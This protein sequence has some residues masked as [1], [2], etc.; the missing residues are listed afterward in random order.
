VLPEALEK[1]PVDLLGNLLPRHLEIIYLINHYF[2]QEVGAKFAADDQ[3]RHENM[4]AMS[5]VEE[6]ENKSIR[7]ANLSIV[8]SH[9]VNGVAALHTELVKDKIFWHFN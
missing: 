8:A 3:K 6:G 7:M 1:W 4:E 9:A 5:L 2:M